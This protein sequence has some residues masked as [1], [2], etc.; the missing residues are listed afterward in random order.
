MATPATSSSG[1]RPQRPRADATAFSV[2]AAISFSHLL[3]DTIQ[4]LI[5]AI[6]PILKASFA[7]SFGQ[8]GMLTLALLLTASLLQPLVGL[9]SDRHSTPYSLVIGMSVSLAGLLML[10]FAHTYSMLLLAAFL[11]VPHG[12]SSIA[13]CSV[14]ALLAIVVLW[15]IGGWY[16][17]RRTLSASRHAHSSVA[18]RIDLS[19][20]RVGWSL[21]I[22]AALIF[23]KYFYLA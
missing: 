15:R 13:W 9:Y 20:A 2:L 17:V 11:V 12:Q 18:R 22:L 6:Y 14:L 8:I 16:R 5:P 21:A 7:L 23:S 4:S 3:N 10:A 1:L 19:P